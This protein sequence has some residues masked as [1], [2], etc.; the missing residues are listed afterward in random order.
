MACV[1]VLTKEPILASGLRSVLTPDTQATFHEDSASLL[2][3][4]ESSFSGVVLIESESGAILR[5]VGAIRAKCPEAKIILWVRNPPMS[6]IRQAIELGVRGILRKDLSVELTHRCLER[7]S[8]GELWLERGL[9]EALLRA[10]TVVLSSRQQQLLTL[11][12]KGLSN[13]EIATALAL[14][15]GTVKVYLSRLFRKVGARD[16]FDLALY[17]IRNGIQEPEPFCE[18]GGDPRRGRRVMVSYA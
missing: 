13:K 1:V 6:E 10:K 5:L 4:L 17:G 12:S 7:V 8:Q 18:F 11:I 15:E 3:G 16:R 2:A 9:T 14:S